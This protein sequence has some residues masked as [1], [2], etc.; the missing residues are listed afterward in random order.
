MS[1]AKSIL[2]GLL[3]CLFENSI[4][5][6]DGVGD[7]DASDFPI[8]IKELK[9]AERSQ[10][11]NYQPH[12]RDGRLN[13]IFKLIHMAAL[14]ANRGNAEKSQTYLDSAM[15]HLKI[16]QSTRERLKKSTLDYFYKDLKESHRA[17]DSD[18]DR[19]GSPK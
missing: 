8:F 17:P 5:A 1:L 2:I 6:G 16:W 3:F 10:T 18:S 12:M 9:R 13:E 14:E 15:E 4:L 7:Y 19:V 11:E